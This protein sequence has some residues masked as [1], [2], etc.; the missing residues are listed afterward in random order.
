[1]KKK[2]IY[3]YSF[4]IL[5][6][7]V[8]IILVAIFVGKDHYKRKHELLDK[9]IVQQTDVK[10]DESKSFYMNYVKST[11]TLDLFE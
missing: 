9:K 3:I 8:S 2:Q 1:M 4:I 11:I 7:L 6:L 5:L 10:L